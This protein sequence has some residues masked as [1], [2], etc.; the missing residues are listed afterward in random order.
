MLLALTDMA[1]LQHSILICYLY[2]A[3]KGLNGQLLAAIGIFGAFHIQDA[4]G[5]NILDLQLALTAYTDD[6]CLFSV[7]SV[8]LDELVEGVAVARLE[9]NCCY[10]LKG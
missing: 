6:V 2:I 4:V 7:N 1:P 5:F 10:T 3:V 8:L 9:K